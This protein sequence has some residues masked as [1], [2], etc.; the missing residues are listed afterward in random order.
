MMRSEGMAL[1]AGSVARLIFYFA[2]L[3]IVCLAG[4]SSTTIAAEEAADAVATREYNATAALQNSGLYGRAAEKWAAFIAKHPADQRL[5]R[6][7]Y[8]LGICQLHTKKFAEAAA[9]FA[10]C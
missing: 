5:D 9:I 10:R 4:I 3:G 7:H 8:Y 2:A 6:A 1:R